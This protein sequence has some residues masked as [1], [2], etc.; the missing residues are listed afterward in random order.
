MA[1]KFFSALATVWG[2]LASY[3]FMLCGTSG[4]ILVYDDVAKH[5]VRTNL[6][7]TQVAR[8]KRIANAS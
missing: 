7:R 3:Q 1:D 5:Y 6:T 4:D 2:L 8:L